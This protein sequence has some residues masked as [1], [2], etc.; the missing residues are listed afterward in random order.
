[1][2]K[3]YTYLLNRPILFY[4]NLFWIWLCLIL[5]GSSIPSISTPHLNIWSYEFRL[6]HLF[7]WLEYATLIFIFVSWRFKK[8][9]LFF[10]RIIWYTLLLG[11]VIAS[12]DEVHQ[13]FIPG[14]HFTIPDWIFNVTGILTGIL[15]SL[16]IWK[17]VYPRISPEEEK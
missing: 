4:R 15:F 12:A 14:R 1:M 11:V 16:Y 13:L 5:I 6:D 2:T 8:N 17:K 10:K 3:I 9:P 7:H